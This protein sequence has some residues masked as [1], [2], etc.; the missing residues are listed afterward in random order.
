MTN[1]EMVDEP[2]D[3]GRRVDEEP[4]DDCPTARVRRGP[5]D[6]ARSVD[7]EPVDGDSPARKRVDRL[8]IFELHYIP[9]S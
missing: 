6:V 2:V 7:A 1:I 5:V 4:V 8:T 9:L 3:E